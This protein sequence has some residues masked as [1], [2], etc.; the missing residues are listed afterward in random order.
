MA[1]F[2]HIQTHSRKISANHKGKGNAWTSSDIAA[3]AR[4]DEEHSKHVDNPQKPTALV[5]D[6]TTLEQQL[7]D[8][9]QD[10]KITT[11]NGTE[12]VARSDAR[13]MVSNVYSWP[14]HVDYYDEERLD[15]FVQDSLEFHEKEFGRVDAAVLHLDEEFPHVHAYT[16]D[17]AAKE[18]HPG[19][20]AKKEAYANGANSKDAN[21]AYRTAMEGFQD[22]FYNEV[23]KKNGLDRVGPK[24]QRLSRK[25]WRDQKQERL[26]KADRF[27]GLEAELDDMASEK[28]QAQK[29]QAD[30]KAQ[31][32][33]LMTQKQQS[34]QLLTKNKTEAQRAS[35]QRSAKLKELNQ[36]EKSIEK[37]AGA[38]NAV[39]SIFGIKSKREKELEKRV[40]S[41]ESK[42][43]KVEKKWQKYT[44]ALKNKLSDKVVESRKTRLRLETKI[45]QSDNELY[46]AKNKLLDATK[47]LEKYKPKLKDKEISNRQDAAGPGL[48][49]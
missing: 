40:Q 46:D 29:R 32:D 47:E 5:G 30:L 20:I 33:A 25:E 15:Q 23:G 41:A 34:E 36:I 9:L 17:K 13:V 22:R 19:E 31:N 1:Q 10:N 49:D 44:V 14:E 4:R 3:E 18:L 27:R 28:H 26:N 6:L 43:K 38:I 21:K 35:Q 48:Q 24:R 37:K 45:N 42:V 2:A 16:F 11:K 7:D 39:K 12:R 8:Y